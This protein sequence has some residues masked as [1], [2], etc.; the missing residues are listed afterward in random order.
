MVRSVIALPSLTLGLAGIAAIT[1]IGL[2]QTLVTIAGTG[3]GQ[4]AKLDQHNTIW[5]GEKAWA[6]LSQNPGSGEGTLF[7]GDCEPSRQLGEYEQRAA[8]EA[9]AQL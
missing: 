1:T 8:Q 3:F 5:Q 9:A 2:T 4:G 7:I 6:Q